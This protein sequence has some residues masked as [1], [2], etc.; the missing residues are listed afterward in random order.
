MK[1]ARPIID[2]MWSVVWL[3]VGGSL[4]VT[5]LKHVFFFFF[6]MNIKLFKS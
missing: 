5:I 2:C 1:I 6:E 3:N 4:P